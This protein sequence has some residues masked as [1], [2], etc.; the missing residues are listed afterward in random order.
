MSERYHIYNKFIIKNIVDNTVV[1]SSNS[2]TIPA[3]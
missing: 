1:S 2:V 3:F